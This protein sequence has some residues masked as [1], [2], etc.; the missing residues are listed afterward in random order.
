MVDSTPRPSYIGRVP[1]F[2]GQLTVQQSHIYSVLSDIHTVASQSFIEP[3]SHTFQ[4]YPSHSIDPLNNNL[5]R[6]PHIPTTR[7]NKNIVTPTNHRPRPRRRIPNT[8]IPPPQ[9]KRRRPTRP[10]LD[11]QLCET[12]KL[13]ERLASTR[14][15]PYVQLRD[16]GARDAAGVGDVGGYGCDCVEEVDGATGAFGA[17]CWA[18][19]GFTGDGE[20]G[21]GKVCVGEAEAEFEAGGYVWGVELANCY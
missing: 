4:K 21:V 2:R 19:G 18:G 14:R 13:L 17:G 10:S 16:F 1:R 6:Q 12:P 20:T 3:T 9:L 5:P 15:V 8:Q 11:L 7:P